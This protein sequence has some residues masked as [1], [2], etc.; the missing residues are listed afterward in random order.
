MPKRAKVTDL[1][2]A[3]SGELTI[4][5]ARQQCQILRDA[6]KKKPATILLDL[7][8]II[9]IDAAG[10]QLLLW[11][12]KTC[13]EQKVLWHFS[14]KSDAVDMALDFTRLL[15]LGQNGGQAKAGNHREVRA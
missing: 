13:A 2:C 10:L 4:Y 9:E 3:L 7:L 12:D 5:T 1:D 6:L 14:A 8:S 11:F 15:A